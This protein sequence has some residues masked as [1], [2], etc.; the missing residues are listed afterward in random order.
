MRNYLAFSVLLLLIGC[1]TR[2]PPCQYERL[3][4]EF[5][6][7][8]EFHYMVL[9]PDYFTLDYPGYLIGLEKIKRTKVGG[10]VG[11]SCPAADGTPCLMTDAG[12]Y[13]DGKK[14]KAREWIES[15]ITGGEGLFHDFKVIFPTHIAQFGSRPSVPPPCVSPTGTATPDPQFVFNIYCT[16]TVDGRLPVKPYD[17]ID[18][19]EQS[20]DMLSCLRGSLEKMIRD[21]KATHVFVYAMGWNTPQWLALAN[22]NDLYRNVVRA[23]QEDG[24]AEH[25]FNPVF[26]GITWPSFWDGKKLFVEDFGNKRNDADEIGITVANHILQDMVGEIKKDVPD[27]KIVLVGH[28]LGARLVTR[29]AASGFLL[30]KDPAVID[31]VIGLEGAFS[32]NQFLDTSYRKFL[33]GFDELVKHSF[34]TSSANDSATA[35]PSRLTK[36]YFVGA[37]ESIDGARNGRI[38]D[39]EEIRNGTW[40]DPLKTFAII[41]LDRT[42]RAIGGIPADRKKVL[43]DATKIVDENIPG[44]GGGAHSDIYSIEMGR[45][46]WETIRTCTIDNQ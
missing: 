32:I 26:I 36:K 16:Q 5:H 9:K 6:T 35:T 31:L 42:G 45:F 17:Y 20:W 33:W 7:S 25:S 27:L 28:S 23:A 21:R 37:H 11:G 3:R 39:R 34:Y 40:L 24:Y 14:A 15:N 19:Y 30:K 44:T 4:K 38:V 10:P 18:L 2:V 13:R 43:V 22:F 1:A 41:S 46:I 12:F 29:A 8:T